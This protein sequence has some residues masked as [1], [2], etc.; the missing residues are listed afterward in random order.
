MAREFQ[1]GRQLNKLNSRAVSGGSG[2]FPITGQENRV[3]SLGQRDV[4]GV[5][6]S[7]IAAQFPGA[8]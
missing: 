6:G 7:E 4:H 8:T 2:K 3:Q 5:I 1:K